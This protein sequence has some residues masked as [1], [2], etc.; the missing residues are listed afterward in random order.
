MPRHPTTRVEIAV[1][2]IGAI[3]Q[4][5]E[6]ALSVCEEHNV[7]GVWLVFNELP[8]WVARGSTVVAICDRYDALR[9]S[10]HFGASCRRIAP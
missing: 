4:A 1:I 2:A 8:I 9:A 5:A 10:H 7:T 6:E 3:W